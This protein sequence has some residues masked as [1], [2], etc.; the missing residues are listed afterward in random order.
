MRTVVVFYLI[1]LQLSVKSQIIK[2][3]EIP[4][5]VAGKE[6]KFPLMGGL[7]CVQAGEFDFNLDGQ[8]DLILFDRV[9]D[10]LLPLVFSNGQ[11]HYEPEYKHSMPRLKD[12]VIFND[13]NKDGF[14]DIFASSAHTEPIAGI[15]VYT[16]KNVGGQLAFNK[17]DIGDPYKIFDAKIIYWL[18]GSSVTNLPADYSDLLSVY[19]I[20]DDGDQDIVL[21]EPGNNRTSLFQNVSVERGYGLDTLVYVFAKRCYG[22]FVEDGLSSEIFLSGSQDTCFDFWNPVLQTRHSGST[23]LTTDLNGDGLFDML[24]GDLLSPGM[25]ALFNGGSKTKPWMISKQTD[26]PGG[27]DSINLAEFLGAFSVDVDHDQLKDILISPNEIGR[28]ENIN[29]LWYY[30]NTGTKTNPKFQLQTKNLFASEMIDLGSGSDPC[31]VDYNQDGLTDILVGTE[32]IFINGSNVRDA[33]LVLFKNI[34]SK[35]QPKYELVDS[36]YLNFREFAF[37]VDPYNSF[38]PSFGDLDGDGDLDLLVGEI[39]GQFFYAENIAG[40]G[41]P[42]V[43]K[44][45]IYPYKDLSVKAFSSPVLIDL[46]R[47]GLMDI[48]SGAW[49]NT[50]DASGNVCGSLYYFQNTGSLGQPEFD[51]DYKKAPNSNC[52]GKIIIN[53]IGS[54]SYSAP[55]IIDIN[56]SYKMFSGNIYGEVKIIGNI[57]QNVQGAFTMENPNYGQLLEGERTRLSLADIDDDGILD[58][59]CGN[60]RGGLAIFETTYKTNGT[61][62]TDYTKKQ[63]VLVYPNPS[64]GLLNLDNL[65]DHQMIVTIMSAQAKPFKEYTIP[66]KSKIQI[67]LDYLNAGL[68]FVSINSGINSKLIRWI[69]I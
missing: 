36:N 39:Y 67:N 63:S 13:Y 24:I 48:V 32:G 68:Y 47:D 51:P 65:S 10:V 57:D 33:R 1:L 34:G 64:S 29:N 44:K 31:F 40:K 60:S 38:S 9:G 26:W 35:K 49:I 3:K 27:S 30:R 52:L 56:G 22:G 16:T 42:F 66:S 15:E 12:W 23:V 58:M 45:P 6:L 69:K 53:G 20:D 50:N 17:F 18:L 2:H 11:Y 4:F 25:V 46:N 62:A 37:G 61:I 14:N 8:K 5:I 54:K 28:S 55:E 21:F 43:F 59:I 7:N 41:N 19:D